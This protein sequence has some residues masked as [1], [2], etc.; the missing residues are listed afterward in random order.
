M[1]KK[2]VFWILAIVL[3]AVGVVPI[4]EG[5]CQDASV[6]TL[7]QRIEEYRLR[8]F[9]ENVSVFLQDQENLHRQLMFIGVTAGNLLDRFVPVINDPRVRCLHDQMQAMSAEEQRE[10][11][12]VL[13]KVY[14]DELKAYTAGRDTALNESPNVDPGF[15]GRQHSLASLLFLLSQFSEAGDRRFDRFLVELYLSELRFNRSSQIGRF[16]SVQH[17][18]FMIYLAKISRSRSAEEVEAILDTCLNRAD[19]PIS[20]HQ[21]PYVRGYVEWLSQDQSPST[22]NEHSKFPLL[23]NTLAQRLAQSGWSVYGD[24]KIV[25]YRL[26]DEIRGAMFPDVKVFNDVRGFIERELLPK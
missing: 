25:H 20:D 14:Q 4:G 26:I 21:G 3:Y 24:G 2:S 15:E 10:S 8:P 22:N 9:H 23:A 18:V 1:K 5:F 17:V 13:A 7:E 11:L 16:R 6:K 19:V 12:N